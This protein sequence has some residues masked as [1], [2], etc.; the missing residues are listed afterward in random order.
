M[1]VKYELNYKDIKNNSWRVDIYSPDYIGTPIQ[2]KGDGTNCLNLQWGG[3]TQDDPYSEHVITSTAT[4]SVISTGI[5]LNELMLIEGD[6]YKV[7]MYLNSSLYW[8]GYMLSD[9]VNVQRQTIAYPVKLTAIDGLSKLD[10]VVFKRPTIGYGNI[11]TNGQLGN[12]RSPMNTIRLILQ[13]SELLDNPL[14]IRWMSSLKS[15]QYPNDDGLS[16]RNEIDPY[17][18]LTLTE[19]SSLWWLNDLVRPHHC[20]ITQFKGYWYIINKED[21]IANNGVFIGYEIPVSTGAVTSVPYTEDLNILLED[22]IANDGYT[23]LKKSYSNINVTYTDTTDKNNVVPNPS[24]DISD[25]DNKPV[26]WKMKS[27][28]NYKLSSQTPLNGEYVGKSIQVNDNSAMPQDDWLTFGSIPLDTTVLFKR[29]TLGFIFSPVSGYTIDSDGNIQNGQVRAV[30]KYTGYHDGVLK[31]LYLNENGYWQ[32]FGLTGDGLSISGVNAYSNRVEISFSGLVCRAGQYFNFEATENT[33]NQP[34]ISISKNY[35]FTSDLPIDTALTNLAS[36]TGGVKSG[37]IVIYY[38]E[39]PSNETAYIT[40]GVDEVTYISFELKVKQNDITSV[41][42]QSTGKESELK[43][44]NA[45]EL[46]KA[47]ESGAGLL[48]MEFYSKAGTVMRMDDVYFTVFDNHDLYEISNG[49]KGSKVEYNLEISSGFSGHMYS[50]Y[51]N[52]Y[53]TANQSMLWGNGYTLTE[54]YGR[55]VLNW[56]N[57]PNRIFDGA[58]PK[59]VPPISFVTIDGLK[60]IHLSTSINCHTLH[61]KCLLFEAKTNVQEYTVTHKSSG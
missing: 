31:N 14:P 30:I 53:T 42:F 18:D 43:L 17:G 9:G 39:E 22:N 45:G 4:I 28:N 46:I 35:T 41:Q 47:Q 5:D 57:R 44:A 52:N 26:Y 40:G 15:K 7:K 19:K 1:A 2:L 51:M 38:I 8:S 56:F 12:S 29:A 48:T 25:I 32:G 34:S 13:D 61:T 6:D 50:S 54:N 49:G 11:T 55:S 24:F 10:S 16:G 33:P 3:N 60:Y 21:L 36:S 37:N 23:I 27:G 20:W 58:I 59:I